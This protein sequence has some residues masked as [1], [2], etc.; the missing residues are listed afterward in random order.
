MVGVWNTV[1]SVTNASRRL[2]IINLSSESISVPLVRLVRSLYKFRMA[3][4]QLLV[5]INEKIGNN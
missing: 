3:A 4:E 2:D 1:N 5:E